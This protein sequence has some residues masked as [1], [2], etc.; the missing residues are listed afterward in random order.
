[1]T[2][3]NSFN[4][5]NAIT[6]SLVVTLFLCEVGGLVRFTTQFP[7]WINLSRK[8]A[9]FF[10][11][12][13]MILMLIG[14][15]L[16]VGRLAFIVGDGPILFLSAYET[17]QARNWQIRKVELL[18]DFLGDY[19]RTIR[20]YLSDGSTQDCLYNQFFAIEHGY[21]GIFDF[22]NMSDAQDAILCSP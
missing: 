11:Q 5:Q 10:I 1:M 13:T 19:Y 6:S 4:S 22:K 16:F 2:H 21:D 17:A 20:F 14:E 15:G 3:F 8:T 18:P 12:V 9:H 7:R